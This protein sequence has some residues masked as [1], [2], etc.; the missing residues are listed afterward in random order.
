[1]QRQWWDGAVLALLGDW[2]SPTERCSL[3]GTPDHGECEAEWTG[4]RP[5]KSWRGAEM[6]LESSERLADVHLR[7][8]EQAIATDPELGDS[9]SSLPSHW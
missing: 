1:M 7:A 8:S 4:D 2:G 6:A 3:F 5:S 9:R